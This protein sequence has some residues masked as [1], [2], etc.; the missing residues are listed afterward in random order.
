MNQNIIAFILLVQFSPPVI[1]QTSPTGRP[2]DW[3]NEAIVGAV[4]A[5][6]GYVGRAL[7]EHLKIRREAKKNVADELQKL[8]VLLE[9]SDALFKDQNFKARRLLTLL[10]RRLADR[11]PSNLGFDEAFFRMYEQ[12]NDDEKE[13]H[14]LIRSITVTSLVR[15]NS[16]MSEWLR[17]NAAI[18][19]GTASDPKYQRLVEELSNLQFHLNLWH[20][21]YAVHMND[22]KRC[23]V[24]LADEKQQGT[25][26]PPELEPAL[27]AVLG[28]R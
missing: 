4:F 1:A 17:R 6:L 19:Q 21:K 27:A 10:E 13:L 23:L 25:R 11:V 3:L 20:A 28:S 15:V 9:E 24:Y 7:H 22:P 26:F 8:S 16:D 18:R 2:D 14:S 5:L 12:L